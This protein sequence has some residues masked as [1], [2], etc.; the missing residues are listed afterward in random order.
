[1]RCQPPSDLLWCTTAIC[2]SPALLEFGVVLKLDE[3][4]W[5]QCNAIQTIHQLAAEFVSQDADEPSASGKKQV[6]P[7][8]APCG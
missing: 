8:A 6:G 2:G 1:M 4:F 3:L 5:V 7:F